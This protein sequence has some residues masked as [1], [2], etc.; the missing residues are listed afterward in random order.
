MSSDLIPSDDSAAGEVAALLQRLADEPRHTI[1]ARADLE[2]ILSEARPPAPKRPDPTPRHRSDGAFA[3]SGFQLY[4]GRIGRYSLLSST[5]EQHLAR[6]IELGVLAAERLR[7]SDPSPGE[8]QLLNVLVRTGA[9]ATDRFLS[10][11]LRLVVHLARQS[12]AEGLPLEDRVQEGNIGLLHALQKFDVALGFKFSTYGTWWIKQ[13]ISRAS[14]DQG[15]VVRLP[16]HVIEEVRRVRRMRR[17]LEALEQFSMAALSNALEMP[18]SRIEY[19]ESLKPADSLGRKRYLNLPEPDDELETIEHRFDEGLLL[20]EVDWL[21]PREA[22]ILKC[23]FGLEGREEMTLD[24][25]GELLNL[26]RERIRQIQVKALS[27]LQARL[28]SWR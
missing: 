3:S 24:Q 7:E 8:R 22:F 2:R 18:V 23:R 19:I 15:R 14:A 12:P 17:H 28:S 4:L 21:G 25:I 26:T 16:V 11:N 20:R 5:D 27:R 9:K 10:A 1:L 6:E 13:A